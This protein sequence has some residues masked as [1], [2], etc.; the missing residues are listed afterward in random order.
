MV[1]SHDLAAVTYLANRIGVMHLGT[2]VACH[3][4]LQT[5]AAA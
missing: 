1:I 5:P 3:V 2:I 4:P